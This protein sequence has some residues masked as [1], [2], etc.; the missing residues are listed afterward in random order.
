MLTLSKLDCIFWIAPPHR[1][2]LPDR[3]PFNCRNGE[4]EQRAFETR[5]RHL[6]RKM[7]RWREYVR[8]EPVSASG[9]L[10][11]GT[12]DRAV[13]QRL[14]R[15]HYLAGRRKGGYL[16]GD[17]LCLLGVPG[18]GEDLPAARGDHLV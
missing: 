6:T 8:G 1:E 2:V 15:V 17:P 7:V 4:V 9:R 12:G 16:S 10:S 11:P 18:G 13:G 14:Q 5:A 3:A